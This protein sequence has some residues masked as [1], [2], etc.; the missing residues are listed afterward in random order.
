MVTVMEPILWSRLK[1]NQK[2]V[3]CSHNTP[4]TTAAVGAFWQASHYCSIRDSS[5]SNRTRKTQ[6]WL[7]LP[8]GMHGTFQVGTSLTSPCLV[9]QVYGSSAIGW[10]Y[11]VLE[12]DQERWQ[13][14]TMFEGLH[15]PLTN[16]EATIPGHS[17]GFL[18]DIELC[19]GEALCFSLLSSSFI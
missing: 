10:Y 4:A 6:Q 15:N 5:D 17:L 11:Q 14:P 13:Y 1:S 7:F 12:G 9:I 18:F 19:L 3:G 16:K 8:S 2:E